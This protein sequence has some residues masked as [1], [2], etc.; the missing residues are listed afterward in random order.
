M[1]L[2]DTDICIEILRGNEKVIERRKAVDDN[3]GLSF[4][5][6]AELYYGSG[7]SGNKAKNNSLIEQLLLSMIV[8]HSDFNICKKFGELKADLSSR[9]IILTDADIFIAATA[10]EKT[11]KLIT[12]NIKHFQRFTELKLE[13]WS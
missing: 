9:A 4:I 8:F 2:L 5:S 13:D 12:G 11:D 10:I 6:I 1:I 7:I 3:V